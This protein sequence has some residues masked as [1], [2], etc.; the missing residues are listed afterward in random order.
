MATGA[1]S[2]S[3]ENSSS[4]GGGAGVGGGSGGTEEQPTFNSELLGIGLGLGAAAVLGLAYYRFAHLSRSSRAV[5]IDPPPVQGTGEQGRPPSD[6]KATAV[7]NTQPPPT[8]AEGGE[9]TREDI[10]R[11]RTLLKEQHQKVERTL[12]SLEVPVIEDGARNA[13]TRANA[14]AADAENVRVDVAALER[15]VIRQVETQLVLYRPPHIPQVP[16]LPTVW[17]FRLPPSPIIIGPTAFIVANGTMGAWIP[18][19]TASRPQAGQP[20]LMIKDGQVEEQDAR[21]LT[22][23]ELKAPL[24]ML[25]DVKQAVTAAVTE[26][27]VRNPTNDE[28][29][30]VREIF[31]SANAHALPV[32]PLPPG[33]NSG[34]AASFVVE[35]ALMGK[36]AAH[37][38]SPAELLNHRSDTL[39]ELNQRYPQFYPQLPVV[40]NPLP[41]HLVPANQLARLGHQAQVNNL[42]I[43]RQRVVNVGQKAMPFL[44]KAFF[45]ADEASELTKLLADLESLATKIFDLRNKIAAWI[46]KYKAKKATA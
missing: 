18:D 16:L 40:Q 23:Q 42:N 45:L 25:E 15:E 13:D 43:A 11:F 26:V 37:H 39:R 4:G 20:L 17:E 29:A 21:V 33:R 14:P 7:V 28:L 34:V 32:W 41:Q 5:A 31:V 10:E 24:L 1:G 22:N 8:F 35:K 46:V 3:G 9:L 6:L 36:T 30:R 2:G 38:P 44:R 19:T 27:A 12:I